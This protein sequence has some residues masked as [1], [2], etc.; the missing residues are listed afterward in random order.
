MDKLN[1]TLV[2]GYPSRASEASGLQKDQFVKVSKSRS[3]WYRLHA[4]TDKTADTVSFWGNKSVEVNSSYSRIE[5][6]SGLSTPAPASCP[7]SQ[8]TLKR[9]EKSARKSS[10]IC[11][12]AAGFSRWLSKVQTSMQAQLRKIPAEQSKGKSSEKT[13]SAIGEFQYLLNFNSSI[14]Q[15]MAKTME[16]LSEFVFINVANLTLASRDAYLAHI[17][18]GI[19]QDT[20]SALRQAPIHL[21]KLFP[22][23]MLKRATNM[24][25]KFA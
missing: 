11:N 10:Y 23:Q 18:V 16:H 5:H 21:D 7:L 25:I 3:R 15:W 6:S 4:S 19:K 9:W 8:D 20:L 1:V 22:D 14:T 12:Q 2:E 24:K 13:S 17:K